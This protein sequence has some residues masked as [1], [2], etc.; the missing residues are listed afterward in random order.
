M[1]PMTK[2]PLATEHALLGCLWREPMHAYQMHRT[3]MEARAL[4]LVWR[5]KQAQLY[6][7]L[8]R[9]E[10]AGY[11]ASTTETQGTRPPRK[12]LHLTSAGRHAYL[13]WLH[14]PVEH[15]R[16]FRIEFLAK[17]FWANQHDEQTVAALLDAQREACRAWL[18]DL[19]TRIAHMSDEQPFERLVQEFRAGQIESILRWLDTCMLA[20]APGTPA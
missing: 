5:L 6:A 2:L 19:R 4:G 15:G 10:D 20:L 12:M 11:I 8:T 9:L 16:D 14:S 18:D 13:T 7:L 3:L 1:S 17:L